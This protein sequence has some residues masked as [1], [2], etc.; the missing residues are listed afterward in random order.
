MYSTKSKRIILEIPKNGSRTLVKTM[1]I[2][3]GKQWTKCAGHFTLDETLN[4]IPTQVGVKGYPEKDIEVIAV[5]RN[6]AERLYSQVCHYARNKNGVTLDDAM[7][8]AWGQSDVVFKPQWKFIERQV[9][10]QWEI[11]LRVFPMDRLNDATAYL[12]MTG[13]ALRINQA[14]VQR[15]FTMDQLISHEAYDELM[16][17][18]NHYGPDIKLWLD[19]LKRNSLGLEK[20]NEVHNTNVTS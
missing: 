17:S 14:P 13:K 15:P 6:P 7:T 9:I 12:G 20:Y 18:I 2:L 1:H 5:I 11:D 8:V 10:P 19:A 4:L 3:E 16:D